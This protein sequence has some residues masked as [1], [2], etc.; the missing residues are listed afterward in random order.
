MLAPMSASLPA[1]KTGS[2]ASSGSPPAPTA[3]PPPLEVRDLHKRL[4]PT[5]AVAGVELALAAGTTCV[6]LGEPGAGKSTLLRL[7]LGFLPADSGT[8]RVLGREA[9]VDPE[10]RRE[11][12]WLGEHT[13][14]PA[15][16]RVR[17]LVRWHRDTFPGFD[18]ERDLLLERAFPTDLARR[19]SELS[20]DE[21]RVLLLRLALAQGADFLILDAPLAGCNPAERERRLDAI[22]AAGKLRPTTVLFSD[23]SP[24][25]LACKVTHAAIMSR[26]RLLEVAP[27]AELER[28]VRELT[29]SI[30]GY[31]RAAVAIRQ[32]GVVS[33]RTERLTRI[34]TV[35]RFDEEFH[36][37]V[38]AATGGELEHR[39]LDL[40][41][42]YAAYAD[43]SS[44]GTGTAP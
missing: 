31:N 14:P 27:V 1:P 34:V 2:G 42:V 10:V 39:A 6:L 33:V 38:M 7:I 12:G 44:T 40:E 18:S 28:D 13:T 19:A 26:G 4:G 35:R 16:S 25:G 41:Q 3:G 5:A 9:W 36:Q 21:R 37:A 24:A 11:I 8:A 15:Y 23:E 29:L 17:D 32:A 20:P 30:T 43:L 22:G